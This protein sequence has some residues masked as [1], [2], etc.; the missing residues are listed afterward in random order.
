MATVKSGH[1][2]GAF[3]AWRLLRD[4]RLAAGLSQHELA[5]RSATTQSAIARYETA[6]ALPDM[7]TLH[8]LLGACGQ[9]LQVQAVPIDEQ[10]RRQLRESLELTPKQRVERNRRLTQLAAKAAAARREGRT[11][12]LVG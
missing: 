2:A 11:R 5:S 4:A 9:R 10:D 12:P 1:N 7:D 6:R 3:P 8:R